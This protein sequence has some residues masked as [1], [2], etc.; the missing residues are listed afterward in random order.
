MLIRLLYHFGNNRGTDK[1]FVYN[2]N[3]DCELASS[4]SPADFADFAWYVC[5][6]Y[7]YCLT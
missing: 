5:S 7:K 2:E 3:H 4:I 6:K 1:Y